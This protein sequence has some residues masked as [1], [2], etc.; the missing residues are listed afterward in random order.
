M[1]RSD[2]FALVT[3]ASTGIGFHLAEQRADIVS[4]WRNKLQTAMAS[5]TPAGML[6]VQHRK[7]AAPGSA[8]K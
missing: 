1:A 5:I 2:K 7:M 3:G 4:G 6:A 8:R